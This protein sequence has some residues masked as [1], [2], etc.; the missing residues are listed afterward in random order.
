MCVK[1]ETM[2][3]KTIHWEQMWRLC[4][5]IYLGQQMVK[6]FVNKGIRVLRTT[7]FSNSFQL[8]NKF[9]DTIYSMQSL[10]HYHK[11]TNLLEIKL[12]H[13]YLNESQVYSLTW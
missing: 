1:D 6:L 7:G 8:D 10:T 3:N 11:K 9:P 4:H 5:N 2:H 13:N 12:V